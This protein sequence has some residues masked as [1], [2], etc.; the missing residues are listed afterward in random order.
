[1]PSSPPSPPRKFGIAP[2]LLVVAV[3]V[4]EEEAVGVVLEDLAALLAVVEEVY[5]SC[6]ETVRELRKQ[7]AACVTACCPCWP[8]SYLPLS[9]S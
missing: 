8:G 3:V 2:A 4:V 6:P 5:S 1:M 7:T 9:L